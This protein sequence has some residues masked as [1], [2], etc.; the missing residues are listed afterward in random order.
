MAFQ[1][2][3]IMASFHKCLYEDI[4]YVHKRKAPDKSNMTYLASKHYL[5]TIVI[6]FLVISI[7]LQN[8][9]LNDSMLSYRAP[10]KVLMNNKENSFLILAVSDLES[11]CYDSMSM[12]DLVTH[13]AKLQTSQIDLVTLDVDY[14]ILSISTFTLQCFPGNINTNMILTSVQLIDIMYAKIE[15]YL[16]TGH[17]FKP[18]LINYDSVFQLYIYNKYSRICT[19]NYVFKK[20]SNCTLVVQKFSIFYIFIDSQIYIIFEIFYNNN[21]SIL[22]LYMK[23]LFGDETWIKSFPEFGVNDEILFNSSDNMLYTENMKIF[24]N[25]LEQIESDN[26]LYNVLVYYKTNKSFTIF[27][28]LYK[29][30]KLFNFRSSKNVSILNSDYLLHIPQILQMNTLNNLKHCLPYKQNF[31]L[32]C[33]QKCLIFTQELP[34]ILNFTYLTWKTI[35]KFIIKLHTNH[36]IV[37]IILVH[38]FLS[39]EL[40]MNFIKYLCFVGTKSSYRGIIPILS[41]QLLKWV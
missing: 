27:P 33:T 28:M 30:T 14:Q 32:H 36:Y 35:T 29:G 16:V 31:T 18:D 6:W 22:L 25:N 17:C 8:Q 2:P 37:P 1:N 38:R 20:G 26:I 11:I 9:Q 12:C 4:N 41:V 24:V 3:Y 7:T 10:S 15:Y 13:N 19:T 39:L 23:V 34:L 5:K 21:S 40:N